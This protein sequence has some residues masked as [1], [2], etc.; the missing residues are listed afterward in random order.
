MAR[1]RLASAWL[2]LATASFAAVGPAVNAQPRASADDVARSVET[3]YA[4]TASIRGRFFQTF[5][6]RLYDRTE[7]SAGRLALAR[8]GRIRFD[9]GRPSTR[10][11]AGNSS[12]FTVWER[13]EDSA[14]GQYA[15]VPASESSFPA[16][17]GVFIGGRSLREDYRVRLLDSAPYR[18]AGAVLELSP[19]RADPKTQR[20]L[21]FVEQSSRL[22]GVVRRIRVD[23]HD[24]NRN[25]FELTDLE[26]N[27]PLDPQ[28]FAFHPPAGALR[29]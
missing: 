12:G 19:R 16:A 20:I 26:F 5:F 14:A 8:P 6:H 17:F 22:R 27:R 10:V 13:T 3:F 24:G 9:Y 4:Q 7:R 11:I 23:D 18:F 15:E 25:K 21:L 1:L 2:A 28:L 29:L